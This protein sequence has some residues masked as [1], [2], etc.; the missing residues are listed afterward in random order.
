M[1]E[2]PW[3]SSHIVADL[4]AHL[5]GGAAAR[6]AAAPPSLASSAS[7]SDS[8]AS[9]VVKGTILSCRTPT[10]LKSEAARTAM[11]FSLSL[12]VLAQACEFLL[13]FASPLP[14]L[15]QLYRDCLVSS[16]NFVR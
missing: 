16:H 2:Q 10:P 4:L 8:W 6:P 1:K 14:A 12:W 15:Q 3:C 7:F 13:V 11:G 5:V 9:S